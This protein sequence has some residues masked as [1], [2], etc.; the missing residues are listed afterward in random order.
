M[1]IPGMNSVTTQSPAYKAGYLAVGAE[2]GVVTLYQLDMLKKM[3]ITT[4]GTSTSINTGGRGGKV[5]Y[6]TTLKSF[7]NLTTQ[8]TLVCFHPSGELVAIASDRKND[9][10]KLIHLPTGTVYTNWPTEKTPIRKVTSLAFSPNGGYLVV[11]NSRGRVLL[12][13]LTH[14]ERT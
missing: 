12:Y 8:V 2:S 7:L 13:R 10:L 5:E 4:S 9:A 3:N 1:M 6:Q 14:F 11:G